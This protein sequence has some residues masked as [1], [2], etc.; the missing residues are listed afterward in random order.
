MSPADTLRSV[1]NILGST[2][3]IIT[4]AILAVVCIGSPFLDRWV[5]RRKR[6]QYQ[7]LYNSKIGLDTVF[8]EHDEDEESSSEPTNPLDRLVHELE[9]LSV[10][11]I[12][13]RNVGSSDIDESDIQPPLSVAFGNREASAF[14]A[15]RLRPATRIPKPSPA[16]RRDRRAPNPP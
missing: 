13:I 10:V 15:S 1:V 12:R 3:G 8:Q 2:P 9:R 4:L 7:V 5:I 16:R 6:I 14:A 11:I